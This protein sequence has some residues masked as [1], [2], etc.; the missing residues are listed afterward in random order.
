MFS[1]QLTWRMGRLAAALLVTVMVQPAL[2]VAAGGAPDPAKVIGPD[3]CGECHK[4]E[5]AIWREAHHAKTLL[6]MPRDDKA[7]EIAEKMD[8]RRIRDDNMCAECHFT[9]KMV[10]GAKEVVAGV[11]CEACHGPAKDWNR[12][13]S[14]FGGKDVTAETETPEHRSERWAAASA[15]GMVHHTDLY[16]LASQCFDCHTVAEEK[17][18]NL[19]GH[20]AGSE[21]ELV[22][23]SQGEIR[24]NVWFSEDRK[25][26][27]ASPERKRVMFVLGKAL[28]LEHAL[29]GVA[30]ATEKDKYAVGMAKRAQAA[31][32]GIQTLAETVSAPEIAEMLDVVK[33]LKLS[34]GNSEPLNAAA[35]KIADAARRFVANHDGGDLAA[36]D[37]LLPQ[38]DK[39]K[40]KP[41]G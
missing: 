18:V 7:R 22:A 30:G 11:S 37:P 31:A 39:Y 5:I 6:D 32:L 9:Q 15:A 2:D 38:P 25:N 19:G 24:H 34:L 27:E 33:S 17:L 35:D 16:T 41:A 40:G 21:F 20:P 36:I 26:R 8:I 29:R 28:D 12:I 14:D 3:E 23:W 4:A 13:H 1:A 10:D